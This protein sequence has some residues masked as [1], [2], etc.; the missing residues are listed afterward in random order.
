LLK[1][2]GIFIGLLLIGGSL[3]PAWAQEELLLEHSATTLQSWLVFAEVNTLGNGQAASNFSSDHIVRGTALLGQLV[4]GIHVGLL[5]SPSLLLF[6]RIAAYLNDQ[7]QQGLLNLTTSTTTGD[8]WLTLSAIADFLA[9]HYALTQS[10]ES[11]TNLL[12]I[13]DSYVLK[14]GWSPLTSRLGVL[15]NAIRV[16][17]FI[18]TTI[19]TSDIEA[20][21]TD[22]LDHQLDFVDFGILDPV[23]IP[24]SLRVLSSLSGGALYAR[25]SVPVEV[26][27]L[28]EVYSNYTLSETPLLTHSPANYSRNLLY[29]GSLIEGLKVTS[30][31]DTVQAAQALAL[32]LLALWQAGDRLLR[33][34][35]SPLDIYPFDPALDYA[36]LQTA[37]LSEEIV[38]K[39]DLQL[40]LLVTQLMEHVENATLLHQLQEA[41]F[42]GVSHATQDEYY[43]VLEPGTLPTTGFVDRLESTSLL[44]GWLARRRVQ[45]QIPI[46]VLSLLPAQLPIAFSTAVV[47]LLAT[48]F[49]YVRGRLFPAV[50]GGDS[51]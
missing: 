40:P 16:Q 35:Y 47:I 46:D 21:V 25:V 43:P 13:A 6:N 8:E 5:D 3:C 34:P 4:A 22:L 32:E 2:S 7:V 41:L 50:G 26:I 42:L 9:S 49:L 23:N 30:D 28:W 45:E 17:Q 51:G 31:S 37:V 33:Q 20:A 15:T 29:L 48:G 36:Q 24:L 44:A 19:L 14:V 39:S 11:R 10:E 12:A 1:W 38:W 18:G 27:A